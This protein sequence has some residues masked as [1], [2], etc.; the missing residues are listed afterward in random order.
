META[1]VA[2]KPQNKPRTT[3]LLALLRLYTLSFQYD[4]RIKKRLSRHQRR[5]RSI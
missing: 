1:R 3:L 4:Y 2:R 5:H